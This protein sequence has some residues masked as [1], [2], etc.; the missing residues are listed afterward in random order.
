VVAE[1]GGIERLD[2]IDART[3]ARRTE[4]TAARG[5]SET[6]RRRKDLAAMTRGAAWGG[7]SLTWWRVSDGG[8]LVVAERGGIERLDLID[9]RTSPQIA[10][11]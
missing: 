2:L 5:L 3:W 7:A 4:E 11:G 1:R 10:P 8:S 9:A 6:K